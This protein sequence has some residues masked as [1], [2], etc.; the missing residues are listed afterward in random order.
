MIDFFKRLFGIGSVEAVA[1][2]PAPYKV[3]AAVVVAAPVAAP[4]ASTNK[5]RKPYRGKKPNK[6]PA[7]K[8]AVTEGKAKGGTGAVKQQ[9][10]TTKKPQAPKAPAAK[11]K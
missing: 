3:E 9:S 4:T 7:A 8:P 6:A 11:K 5:A 2:T 10:A 1:T